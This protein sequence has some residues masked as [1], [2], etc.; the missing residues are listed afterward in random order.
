MREIFK[1]FCLMLFFITNTFA[2]DLQNISGSEQSNAT[3]LGCKLRV[4][5]L[6]KR[7]ANVVDTLIKETSD[8]NEKKELFREFAQA[9]TDII[10][11]LNRIIVLKRRYIRNPHDD[12]S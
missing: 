6:T 11:I 1:A 8:P 10:T 12:Y 5:A 9:I 7:I 3:Y 2:M 4:N